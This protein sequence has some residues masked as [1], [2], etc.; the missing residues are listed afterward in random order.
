[1][2][3]IKKLHIKY[4]V[5]TSVTRDDLPEGGARHFAEV[6]K[7]IRDY[8]P[9]ISV[10]VLIPDFNGS[11]PALKTVVDAAPAV[12]NHNMETVPRLY[13]EVRPE[14]NYWRSIN[15]I[16]NAKKIIDSTVT[17]SGIMLGLGETKEEVVQAMVDL[18]QAG[19]DIL[20]IGQ[21]LSPSLKHHPIVRY[22]PEEEFDEYKKIGEGI[23]FAAVVAGPLVRSSYRAGEAYNSIKE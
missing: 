9:D 7:K 8:D 16:Q 21:Y 22:I 12:L 17:K 1:M 2:W 6:I 13:P 20:T 4:A 3:A 15:L 19:C 14:A 18:H 11:F 23:G 5:I 10:E